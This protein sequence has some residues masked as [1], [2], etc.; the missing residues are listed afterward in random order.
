MALATQWH[1]CVQT[2]AMALRGD[3]LFVVVC[4]HSLGLWL[5]D[6]LRFAQMDFSDVE[7]PRPR[8][9]VRLDGRGWF[10]GLLI[11]FIVLAVLGVLTMCAGCCMCGLALYRRSTPKNVV[12]TPHARAPTAG[13][14]SQQSA[15]NAD[16]PLVPSSTSTT[17]Q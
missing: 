17:P 11:F 15:N 9:N 2:V 16:A 8:I 14:V 7:F 1:A 6:A 4:A 5:Q 10:G 12:V 3:F 13:V